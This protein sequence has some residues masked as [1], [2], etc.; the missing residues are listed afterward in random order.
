MGSSGSSDMV[1]SCDWL[2]SSIWFLLSIVQVAIWAWG[3]SLP[4]C[5][6]FSELLLLLFSPGGGC[7][8]LQLRLCLVSSSLSKVREFSFEYCPQSH[9]T[10]SGIHHQLFWEVNLSPHPCS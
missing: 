2:V 3:N 5:V 7:V 9:E 8:V 10:N 6:R 4:V 1:S